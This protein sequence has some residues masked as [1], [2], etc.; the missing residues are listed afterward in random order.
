MP[1]SFYTATSLAQPYDE[2]MH[3]PLKARLENVLKE[4]ACLQ[5]GASSSSAAPAIVVEDDCSQAMGEDCSQAMREDYSQAMGEDCS[6]DAEGGCPL[7][8]RWAL[9]EGL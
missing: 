2:H 6:Q 5:S 4:D 8:D 1:A 3:E 7:L 9:D